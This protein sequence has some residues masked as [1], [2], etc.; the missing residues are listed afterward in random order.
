MKAMLNKRLKE[1]RY[2]MYLLTLKCT[3]MIII[4]GG[5]SRSSAPQLENIPWWGNIIL[6]EEGANERF[7]GRGQTYAKY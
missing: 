6:R 4:P 1:K 2:A 7:F 5:P 3:K